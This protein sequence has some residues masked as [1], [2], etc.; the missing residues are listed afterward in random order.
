MSKI[1]NYGLIKFLRKTETPMIDCLFLMAHKINTEKDFDDY[2]SQLEMLDLDHDDDYHWYNI[3]VVALY[4]TDG[5]DKEDEEYF[6][7]LL[8]EE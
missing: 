2:V 4:G 1:T 3:G 6:K 5:M 7:C 8:E